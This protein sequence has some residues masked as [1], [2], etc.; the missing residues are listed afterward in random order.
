MTVYNSLSS[1]RISRDVRCSAWREREVEFSWSPPPVTQRN[2]VITSY[3]ISCSP[4]PSSLPHSP[5][6]Q[7]GPHTVAGF[8]PNTHYSCSLVAS[9]TRGSGPPANTSFNTQQD[10]SFF[11]L[12]LGKVPTSCSEEIV[13][14]F[15]CYVKDSSFFVTEFREIPETGAHYCCS[16]E[17]VKVVLFRVWAR[18]D[19]Q[20]AICLLSRVSVVPD[21]SSQTGGNL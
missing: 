6:S 8:S 14:S 20:P 9:N 21:V 2:G 19:R 3:T 18:N 16:S 1:I 12:R 7:S 10:Y 5:T 15:L 13:S 17:G 11:Q 4:S